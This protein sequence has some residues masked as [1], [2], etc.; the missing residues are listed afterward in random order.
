MDVRL[1]LRIVYGIRL[2]ILDVLGDNIQSVMSSSFT[3]RCNIKTNGSLLQSPTSPSRTSGSEVFNYNN[4]SSK[5]NDSSHSK[6]SSSRFY[7][8]DERL[9]DCPADYDLAAQS[10]PTVPAHGVMLSSTMNASVYA[11]DRIYDSPADVMM[12]PPPV[13]SHGGLDVSKRSDR[14]SG[15]STGDRRRH[16]RS[17][18]SSSSSELT[19][20]SSAGSYKTPVLELSSSTYTGVKVRQFLMLYCFLFLIQHENFIIS[21]EVSSVGWPTLQRCEWLKW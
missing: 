7:Q 18:D 19:V 1:P 14:H 10:K 11:D 5:V 13:P 16:H 21:A 2:F 12:L 3:E 9:Y 6:A 8:D 17:V 4:N 15:D 20:V